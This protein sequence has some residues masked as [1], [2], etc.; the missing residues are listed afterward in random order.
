MKIIS[1]DKL[2]KRNN[3]IGQI[4]SIGSLII[5]GVGMFF[6]FKDTAGTYMTLTFTSLIVGFILFQV[7]NYYLNRW[8]KSPRPDEI[9]SQS[10]KGLDDHY[11]LYHYA[12][13]I[14]HLLVGP[15]GVFSLLPYSQAGTLFFDT[16][17][18]QWKQRGGNVFLKAFA[19]EGLGHPETEANYNTE[20]LEKYLLKIGVGT[21]QAK[22]TSLIV[23]TNPKATVEGEGSPAAFVTADKLKD[24][25]RKQAKEKSLNTDSILALI[26]QKKKA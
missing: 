26:N 11:T 3:R 23:F 7:G 6:S 5:L 8:G 1:N 20:Q 18:K 25:M 14:P 21:E 17:K 10:L 19:Q 22:G 9:L 16:K 24:Y 12:T 4:A 13:D 2:I 15:A